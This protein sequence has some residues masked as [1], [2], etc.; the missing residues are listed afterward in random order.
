MHSYGFLAA[1]RQSLGARD[2]ISV[3]N[4][5]AHNTIEAVLPGW[6]RHLIFA[7]S[8]VAGAACS[9]LR[10]S[11]PVPTLVPERPSIR[12]LPGH[13]VAID[14][15][16]TTRTDEITPDYS[17][18]PQIG[19]NVVAITYDGQSTFV[20]SALQGGQ[21]ERLASAIGAYHGQRPLV[22]EGPVSFEVTA[23]GAWSLTLQPM[24]SGGS[25]EFSGAGD[26]VSSYFAPPGPGNWS[27]AHDGQ[28]D[29]LVY[30]HCVGGSIGVEDRVGPVEDTP[31]IEFPR[32]PCF[33]EIVADGTWQLRPAN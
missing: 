15:H 27:I 12:E 25:P 32:G 10:S 33:W 14:G 17:S 2:L 24:S 3:P 7:A 23:D 31:H 29:F 26:G 4:G 9:Q 5:Q 11:S 19:I 28:S 30:A 8:L 21:S 18:G 22:V 20:V 1:V 16:G 13:G 6:T